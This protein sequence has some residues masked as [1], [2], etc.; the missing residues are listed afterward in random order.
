MRAT[1]L[2]HLQALL[3][4]DIMSEPYCV[5]IY[6]NSLSLLVYKLLKLMCAVGPLD[7][8]Y[9]ISFVKTEDALVQAGEMLCYMWPRLYIVFWRLLFHVRWSGGVFVW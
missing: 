1:V 4:I 7:G 8:R 3:F 6:L 2:E 9:D 5:Y